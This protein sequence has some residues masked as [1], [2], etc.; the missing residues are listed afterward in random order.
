M[1]SIFQSIVIAFAFITAAFAADTLERA[2]TGEIKG[3]V[4]ASCKEHIKAMLGKNMPGLVSVDV[5]PGAT[6]DSPRRLVIVAKTESLTKEQVAAAL[7]S[8][9]KNYEILSLKPQP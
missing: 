8:F 1:K 4:C 6:A 7:G 5:L 3:V 9:A 2:Y